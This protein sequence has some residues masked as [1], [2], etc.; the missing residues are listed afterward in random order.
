MRD[1]GFDASV[2]AEQLELAKRGEILETLVVATAEAFAE[3][4]L[5]SGIGLLEANGL[6]DY[7][8]KETLAAYRDEDEKYDWRAIPRERLNQYSSSLSF[9]DAEGMRFHLPAFLIAD[10]RGNYAFDLV[11]NLTQSTLLEDQCALLTESQR[12]VVRK[13]LQF[14]EEEEDHEFDREHIQRALESYWA[15]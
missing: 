5:G 9:F 11:Y 6:D 1:R 14:A 13:Y 10:M 7:A 2:I 4:A 15:E 8:N 3:V 12:K